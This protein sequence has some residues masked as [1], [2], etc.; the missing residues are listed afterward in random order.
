MKKNEESKLLLVHTHTHTHPHPHKG[1]RHEFTVVTCKQPR[2][3]LPRQEYGLLKFSSQKY[4]SA[5][6]HFL[7][8][9]MYLVLYS[10]CFPPFPEDAAVGHSH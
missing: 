6:I 3:N 2:M 5:L 10:N 7:K 1:T 8:I 4:R 9:L